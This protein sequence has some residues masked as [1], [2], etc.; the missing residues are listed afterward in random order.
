MN[1]F[2]IFCADKDECLERRICG[3]GTCMNNEGSFQCMCNFGFE[4]GPREVCQG[5]WISG[6]CYVPY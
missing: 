2:V 1:V 4:R 5:E 3:N 6:D